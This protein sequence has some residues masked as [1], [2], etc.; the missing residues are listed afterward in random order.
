[1]N[2]IAKS[3]IGLAAALVVG[4]VAHGPVGLGEALVDRL[5][6]NGRETLVR[7]GATNAT[8]TMARSPLL[9]RT[10]VLDGTA[11]SF[12]RGGMGSFPGIDRNILAV[13]GIARLRWTS[14][15]AT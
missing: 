10:A 5:E 1:M 7:I 12:Q 13:P 3:L 6:G 8:L 15:P 9:A 4:I 11:N 2:R 14:E